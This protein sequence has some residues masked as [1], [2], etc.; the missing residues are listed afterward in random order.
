V[1]AVKGQG[2]W[3]GV[4]FDGTLSE[5]HGVWRPPGEYGAPIPNMVE[6][7]KRWLEAGWEVRIVTA[8]AQ[9]EPYCDMPREL[10]ISTLQ[11]WCEEHIGARLPITNEKDLGMVALWDDRAVQ[12]EANTGLV[13][14]QQIPDLTDCGTLISVLSLTQH[15]LEPST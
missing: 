2:G 13:R 11:D 3:I 1:S 10:I 15:T 9:R 4:D 6:R 7:V 14:S 5:Y 12:V 8:R